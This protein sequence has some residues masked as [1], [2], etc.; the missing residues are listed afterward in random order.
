MTR[1]LIPSGALGLG[2]D[3]QALMRGVENKPDIIAIDGGSTDSG[4]AYLGKGVSKYSA[5]STKMEWR[6]LLLA[7]D[8]AGVPLVIGTAGTCGTD[9]TV[10]WLFD[11][12]KEIAEEENLSFKVALLY[13]SQPVDDIASVFRAG[14]LRA[15]PAAPEIDEATIKQCTNIV[16]LAGAEQIQEALRTGADVIIAG[17]TTDTA[18]IAALPLLRGDNA[19]AAWHGAKVGECGALATSQPN[20]GV[21]Q[22]DFDAAGFTITPLAKDTY[23]T[24]QSVSAHML[25]E[26]SDPY[27]L[28]E[29]G[30]YLDVTNAKYAAIGD[31]SVRV[32]GSTWETAPY[33]VKLEGAYNSGFQTVSMVMVR[34]RRYVENIESWV[35]DIATKCRAKVID[36]LQL[37]EDEFSIELR[38]IGMTSVLGD[39]EVDA[40]PPR[41]VGVMGI[42][43]A[44][45]A[46]L[47]EEIGKTL[48]PYLLHH[49][50]TEEEPMPTFAFP[51]SPAEMARGATYA[52]CLH[53]VMPLSDPM[54]AFRLETRDFARA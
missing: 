38:I 17:R 31:G 48:N 1:V 22:I 46:K 51:F 20:T 39:L 12:T 47:A 19:G 35:Q 42:V 33:T 36:R 40:R 5:A 34:E 10:D 25:Y 21:I 49:P 52:F 32:E 41:E 27:I 4:P 50:L 16:A 3:S 6:E 29:P 28:H 13:S 15:L 18:T 26:N 8:K 7:R 11:L 53:H 54:D 2:F 14:N 43:T 30:G 24:P 9:S 23:A 44:K 45:T 37:A